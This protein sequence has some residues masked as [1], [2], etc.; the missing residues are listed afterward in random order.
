MTGLEYLLSLHV[1]CS[2]TSRE[3]PGTLTSKSELRR[4]CDNS[5]LRINGVP[6]KWNEQIPEDVNSVTL[7]TKQ[8]KITIW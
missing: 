8:K 5:V 4:W 2:F 1:V 6:I 7:F 3:R